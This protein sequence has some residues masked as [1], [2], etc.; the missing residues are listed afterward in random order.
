MAQL[1]RILTL[2]GSVLASG[3]DCRTARI[4]Y[5]LHFSAAGDELTDAHWGRAD[6]TDAS[7]QDVKETGGGF[8][9][10]RG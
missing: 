2:A 6:G 1:G 9:A 7:E 3:I 8:H 5:A 4:S 10:E